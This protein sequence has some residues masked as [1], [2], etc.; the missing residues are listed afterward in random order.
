[1]DATTPII[2]N[3]IGKP[4]SRIRPLPSITRDCVSRR[5]FLKRR[6]RILKPR[7]MISLPTPPLPLQPLPPTAAQTKLLGPIF[8]NPN[9][10]PSARPIQEA[11]AS[12]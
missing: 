3:Y 6:L 12:Q 2:A 7:L 1:M 5:D 10:A 4:A 8:R 11:R 9:L